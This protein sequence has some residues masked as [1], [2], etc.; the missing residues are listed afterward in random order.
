MFSRKQ[1]PAA[2]IKLLADPRDRIN[3]EEVGRTVFSSIKRVL[4]RSLCD[5][6]SDIYQA[7]FHKGM[8]CSIK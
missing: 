4:W 2:D 7:W 8:G 3:D 1:L 5:P 6:S